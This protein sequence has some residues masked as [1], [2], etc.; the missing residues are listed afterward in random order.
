LSFTHTSDASSVLS[1]HLSHSISILQQ[2]GVQT[3]NSSGRAALVQVVH[4]ALLILKHLL[5]RLQRAFFNT[6]LNR[7]KL[8]AIKAKALKLV[9]QKLFL[10]VHCQYFSRIRTR[11][12]SKIF[13]PH[14]KIKK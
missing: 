7:F 4:C 3:F 13:Y 11:C 6:N 2:S 12:I 10:T 14:E 8:L 5:T 1:I 9:F